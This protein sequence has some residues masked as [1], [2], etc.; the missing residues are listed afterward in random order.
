MTD[1]WPP[2]PEPAGDLN[3]PRR[4]PPTAVGVRTPP[5]P[6]R[7]PSRSTYL[8]SSRKRRLAQA[9]LG[10]SGAF[11]GIAAA[12]I[13]VHPAAVIGGSVLALVGARL[14]GISVRGAPATS[15]QAPLDDR[16]PMPKR[17]P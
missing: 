15:E 1:E 16:M 6:P 10:A 4:R 14:L 5:P 9:F 3:P 13:A 12:S 11:A 2:A 7:H 17:L 8:E